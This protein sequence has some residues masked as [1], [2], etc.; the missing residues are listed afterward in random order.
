MLPQS[1]KCEE[2]ERERAQRNHRELRQTH[3]RQAPF[4]P[5]F[6]GHRGTRAGHVVRTCSGPASECSRRRIIRPR[7]LKDRV[8]G[9]I[10]CIE[11]LF[12]ASL[13]PLRL[14]FSSLL[15]C[16]RGPFDLANSRCSESPAPRHQALH[17]ST[18]SLPPRR[19]PVLPIPPN[20]K[21]KKQDPLSPVVPKTTK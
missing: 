15:I 10:Y 20:K 1:L 14:C 8:I 18:P 19:L 16:R 6:K 13:H 11:A 3:S 2:R 17:S 21:E 9:G 5:E 4:I 7:K 12:P